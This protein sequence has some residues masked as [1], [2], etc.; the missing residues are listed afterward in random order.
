M[1]KSNAK[2]LKERARQCRKQARIVCDEK[3]LEAA[4]EAIDEFEQGE[5]AKY[6]ADNADY[7]TGLAVARLR[8]MQADKPTFPF[9][10][11]DAETLVRLLS[12]YTVAD[13]QGYAVREDLDDTQIVEGAE[14]N[15]LIDGG[16]SMTVETPTTKL[17]DKLR[18]ALREYAQCAAVAAKRIDSASLLDWAGV[19]D[20]IENW[21]GLYSAK[22]REEDALRLVEL[23]RSAAD[24][25]RLDKIIANLPSPGKPVGKAR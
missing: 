10:P 11:F 3:N 5:V 4:L 12:A 17:Q 18:A 21:H 1:K 16:W 2:D 8:D 24:R 25:L 19:I 9:R 7:V 13:Y 23:H 15:T 14:N 22:V 6:F 20:I